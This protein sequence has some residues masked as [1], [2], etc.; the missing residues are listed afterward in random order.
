MSEDPPRLQLAYSARVSAVTHGAHLYHRLAL[1]TA[2]PAGSNPTLVCLR[3]GSWHRLDQEC[4]KFDNIVVQ[5]L[6][7]RVTQAT[8]PAATRHVRP[9]PSVS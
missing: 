2:P 4:I 3:A 8:L 7:V 9:A 1:L 5:V 6:E